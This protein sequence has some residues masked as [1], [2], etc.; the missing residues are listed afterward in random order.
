MST[1]IIFESEYRCCLIV[2]E[3]EPLKSAKLAELCKEQLGWART[4]TYTVLKRLSDR[5]VLQNKNTM[6]TSLISKEQAQVSEVN[7]LIEKKFEGNVPAF[8]AAFVNGRKL[9]K[10]EAD[11]LRAIIDSAKE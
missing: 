2:W 1:P 10:E 5:G 3:H 6:V 7:G 9:K 8:M 11:A 4:T